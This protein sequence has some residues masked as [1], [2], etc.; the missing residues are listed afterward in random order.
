MFVHVLSLVALLGYWAER[1]R[2]IR[3]EAACSHASHEAA[4]QV[5]ERA[6]ERAGRIRAEVRHALQVDAVLSGCKDM[7][8]SRIQ[9]SR[10]T[11]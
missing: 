4:A 7:V 9:L 1:C 3:A 8:S 10:Y 2:R 6:A 5:A 11:M